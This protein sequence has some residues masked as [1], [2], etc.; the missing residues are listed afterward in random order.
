MTRITRAK[1]TVLA[2]KII[3]GFDSPRQPPIHYPRK[4]Y[5]GVEAK[6][7]SGDLLV[8]TV[9]MQAGHFYEVRCA[10]A[11]NYNNETDRF[12]GKLFEGGRMVVETFS[13]T[14]GGQ[15]YSSLSIEHVV[16]AAST[17]AVQ[18]KLNLSDWSSGVVLTRYSMVIMDLGPA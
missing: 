1:S 9:T 6:D 4:L 5:A 3:N 7:G 15:Y 8:A 16:N 11:A 2:P 10:I 13:P 12:Q 18:Y 14:Y 17:G